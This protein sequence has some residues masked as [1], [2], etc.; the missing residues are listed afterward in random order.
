MNGGDLPR[1]AR[2]LPD[3]TGLD[4]EF[5][6]LIPDDLVGR[7]AVGDRTMAPSLV[8]Y[9]APA[10]LAQDRHL[11]G[12]PLGTRGGLLVTHIF[13]LDAEYEFTIGGGRGG[14]R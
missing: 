1:I 5:D 8:S 13:P 11:E 7:L 3:V 14:V 10:G 9:A 4:K 6:Y 12:L 2:V